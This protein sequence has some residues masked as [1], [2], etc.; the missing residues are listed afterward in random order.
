LNGEVVCSVIVPSYRSAG[1]IREC[2]A[3]LIG[4]CLELP[5]EIIVVDSSDDETAEMVRREFPAVN[6]IHLPQQTGPEVA[7]NLGA[8]QARGEMLAFIDSDCV[9]PVDWLGRL[10]SLIGKGYEAV[11]GAIANGNSQSLVSWASYFCEFREF[12]PGD[13]A[14]EVNNVSP[15]NAAYRKA[16]FWAAG[17][18]TV[19]YY[20]MEDQVFHQRLNECGIRICLD[21]SIVVLHMHRTEQ[22][23]FLRHQ[24]RLGW[25][26]ARVLRRIELPGAWL[27]RRPWLV[28]MA[29]PLLIPYR[30]A[31]TVYAVRTAERALVLRRPTLA[32]LCWLGMCQWGWGFF[33]GSG[34]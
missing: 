34:E 11:G 23:A 32:W 30:F 27:A 2:L 25:A 1:T 21:P 6:L 14:R 24:K 31:R 29:L 28:F 3:A 8:R 15:G 19:G 26:N 13:V 20:P 33:Q 22:A 4:Q 10:Y 18:F 16:T 17:G 7:R 12:L 5:Y 9:A